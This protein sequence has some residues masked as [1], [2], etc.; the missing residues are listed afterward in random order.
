MKS[1]NLLK[2]TEASA[3]TCKSQS[4]F[5]AEVKAGI[6][7]PPVKIG[8]RAVAWPEHELDAINTAR[9]AGQSNDE[10]RQLVARMVGDRAKL[11]LVA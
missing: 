10:I 11:K 6:I 9:I 3:K 7:P 5:Y 4:G 8:R 1:N 2:V